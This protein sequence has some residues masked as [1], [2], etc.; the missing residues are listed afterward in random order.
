M[1]LAVAVRERKIIK[2][3][4][5]WKADGPE[6]S[7]IAQFSIPNVVD[8]QGDITRPGAFQQGKQV[9]VA[10]YGHKWDEL[11]VGMGTVIEEPTRTIIDGKF[12]ID[13][14]HGRDTYLTVKHLGAIQ[15][16]SYGYFVEDASYGEIDG[17]FVRYLN[18][19]DVFEVSPVLLGAGSD[20]GTVDIKSTASASLWLPD[21]NT[22]ALLKSLDVDLSGAGKD[23]AYDL[24]LAIKAIAESKAGRVLSSANIARMKSAIEGM[25]T[26]IDIM[27]ALVDDNSSDDGKGDVPPSDPPKDDEG[28]SREAGRRVFLDFQRMQSQ[29]TVG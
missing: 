17:R 3:Q 19:L 25:R 26:A 22:M 1:T 14:T 24:L 6:G 9:A 27:Q 21:G 2:A 18:K 28:D 8:K 12:F 11:P 29:L 5:E 20:T 10:S 7:F 15:E 16:W 4:F 13:T 23:G